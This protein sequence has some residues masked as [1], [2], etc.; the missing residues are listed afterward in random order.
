MRYFLKNIHKAVFAILETRVTRHAAHHFR[1]T[2]LFQNR[3]HHPPR[4]RP[5][6][7]LHNDPYLEILPDCRRRFHINGETPQRTGQRHVLSTQK[8]TIENRRRVVHN[9]PVSKRTKLVRIA[10]E[11]FVG[12]GIFRDQRHDLRGRPIFVALFYSIYDDHR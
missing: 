9:K 7:L 3:K 10:D 1:K 4:H 6:T 2:V 8:G 11:D 5:P 12:T